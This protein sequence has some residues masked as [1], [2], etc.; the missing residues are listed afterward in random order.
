MLW[1]RGHTLYQQFAV[2]GLIGSD[3]LHVKA[4]TVRYHL[5]LNR[6]CQTGPPHLIGKFRKIKHEGEIPMH[7]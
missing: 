1:G 5:P 2:L 7:T 4:D 6:A 3:V